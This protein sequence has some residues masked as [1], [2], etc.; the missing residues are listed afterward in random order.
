MSTR[1]GLAH[2]R[3]QATRTSSV[4]TTAPIAPPSSAPGG[5]CTGEH[6][7]QATSITT[8]TTAAVTPAALRK[9]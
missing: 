3:A 2:Q 9:P 8:P 7:R 1:R 6:Q 4:P 5:S